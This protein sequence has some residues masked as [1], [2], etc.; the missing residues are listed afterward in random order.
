[1]P[2]LAAKPIIDIVLAVADPADEPAYV[3]A[4]EG[5]GFVLRVREPH[6]YEHRLLK[7]PNANVHVFTPVCPEIER[8]LAFRNLLR[9]DDTEREL[10]LHAKRDLAART[11]KYVQNYADAK[12]AV[13]EE[14]TA[15]ALAAERGS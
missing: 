6:W 11:W 13:V 4:L 5:E 10:Y 1:V 14:I 2:G 7:K 15:R 8:M 12:T 3:P 9:R